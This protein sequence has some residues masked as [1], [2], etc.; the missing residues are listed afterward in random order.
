MPYEAGLGEAGDATGLGHLLADDRRG[1]GEKE[2]DPGPTGVQ[3]LRR[4][5]K[6]C[7]PLQFRVLRAEAVRP[8]RGKREDLMARIHGQVNED[9]GKVEK[10]RVSRHKTV[11]FPV[12]IVNTRAKRA[13]RALVG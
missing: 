12:T 6:R 9:T 11:D 3:E 7:V 5:R 10:R 1:D 13:W 8:V 4:V 2:V